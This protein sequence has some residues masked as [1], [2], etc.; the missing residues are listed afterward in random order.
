[1]I[2]LHRLNGSEVVVNA[3]LIEQV[4]PHGTET[5]IVMATNNRIVVQEGVTQVV[6]ATVQYRQRVGLTYVPRPLRRADQS[7]Q[8]EKSCL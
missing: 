3:E 5:V 8:E 2:R 1:M 7:H 4:E 6:E